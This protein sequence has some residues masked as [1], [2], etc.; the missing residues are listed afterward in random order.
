MQKTLN[1]IW[2]IVLILIALG[3]LITSGYLFSNRDELVT[4]NIT[5]DYFIETV[6]TNNKER[7][8]GFIASSNNDVL[9]ENFVS[10]MDNVYHYSGV[11]DMHFEITNKK[12]YGNGKRQCYLSNEFE[13]YITKCDSENEGRYVNYLVDIKISY[14]YANEKVTRDE[15]GLIVFVKDMVDGNYFT[16][17]LVRFD[18]YKVEK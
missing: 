14:I 10:T 12:I 11:S 13:N 2:K 17:K 16:W 9:Y 7:M 4:S 5:M 3:A 8:K 15:K 18:R 1:I 6:E